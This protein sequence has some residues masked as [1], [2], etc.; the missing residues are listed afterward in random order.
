MRD[1][2]FL[3]L[4]MLNQFPVELCQDP[5]IVYNLHDG[6]IQKLRYTCYVF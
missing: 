3:N 5:H 4:L 6:E 1:L 2:R